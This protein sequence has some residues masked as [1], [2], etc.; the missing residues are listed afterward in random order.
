MS[1]T[2]TR[3]RLLSTHL[4]A[5]IAPQGPPPS[6]CKNAHRGLSGLC[7]SASAPTR[8]Q[9]SIAS[10][11]NSRCCT[12]AR[13]TPLLPQGDQPTS[14][15]DITGTRIDPGFAFVFNSVL[16]S[17]MN[18]Q[19]AVNWR[20]CAMI[21]DCQPHRVETL[22][23]AV[24]DTLILGGVVAGAVLAPAALAAEG[25]TTSVFWSGGSVARDAAAEWA[26]ANG[27]ATLEMTETGQQLSALTEGMEWEQAAPLWQSASSQFASEA[28][29]DVHVFLGPTV[30]SSSIFNTIELPALL[31]NPAVTGILFH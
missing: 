31:Q 14:E 7:R 12:K 26:A 15:V 22:G 8:S 5:P 24:G 4:P 16:A 3:L 10:G 27:G 30:S 2:A 19:Y 9:V 1:C 28:V 29:G 23:Q 13:R 6:E 20:N 17:A 21:G 18:A 25:A 11:E